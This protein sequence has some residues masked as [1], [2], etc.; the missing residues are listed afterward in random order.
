LPQSCLDVSTDLLVD[1]IGLSGSVHA[2]VLA[3]VFLG[4]T[5]LFFG[6]QLVQRIVESILEVLTEPHRC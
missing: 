5:L 2:V 3:G 4:F 1:R 6:D